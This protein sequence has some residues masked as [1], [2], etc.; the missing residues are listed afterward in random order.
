MLIWYQACIMYSVYCSTFPPPQ[1]LHLGCSLSSS[2]AVLH[3]LFFCSNW[4]WTVVG[5]VDRGR[6][7]FMERP[8]PRYSTRGRDGKH[9]R[10]YA[11]R[12]W[13]SPPSPS[14]KPSDFFSLSSPERR[15]NLSRQIWSSE[16]G[17]GWLFCS[18]W[19]IR[20]DSL[21]PPPIEWKKFIENLEGGLGLFSF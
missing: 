20:F 17:L 1:P 15:S 14:R 6:L 5:S 2:A 21:P 18:S 12:P 3:L 13:E 19:S 16:N 4:G 11:D 8:R 9:P 7:R 10:A